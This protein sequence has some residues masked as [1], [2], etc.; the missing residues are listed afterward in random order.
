LPNYTANY[1]LK[2]PL[3]NEYYNVEDQN[4]NMDIIDQK[5]KEIEDKVENIEV[6]VTSVNGKTGNVELTAED[7]G[8]ETPSGAQAKV[9]AALEAA[10]QY[11][12]QV[13][14][15]HL[16]DYV[17]LKDKVDNLRIND[18]Q[19]RREIMD[20]KMR[21]DEKSILDFLNKTGIGFFDFFETTEYVDTDN[22]T[23]TVDTVNQEVIFNEGQVLKMLPQQFDATI[24]DVELAIYDKEREY[25]L[26]DVDVE[27][28]Q[29]QITVEPG[30]VEVGDKFY[31]NGEVYEVTGVQEVS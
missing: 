13:L 18:I 23:A 28:T 14:E 24:N 20:I 19:A 12:D 30:T 11:T 10:K 21:L 4:N 27:G 26:S 1:N 3:P 15:S 8:A 25:V 31:Y 22:T 9:D 17:Q 29:I 6:P 5:L 16:E 2:K 7:V